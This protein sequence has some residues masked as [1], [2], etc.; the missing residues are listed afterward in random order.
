MEYI[1]GFI[2]WLSTGF[3]GITDFVSGIPEFIL[4]IFAYAYFWCIKLWIST[5]IFT[6][7]LAYEVAQLIL[8]D[9]E[10]YTLLNA[11]FNSMS[12]D[13]RGIAYALGIVEAI[14][15]FID[16]CATAMV[17]RIMGW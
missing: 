2:D 17:L 16:A 5:Q 13:V 6:I 8:E 7:E 10:V 15:I 9:Y 11:A 3:V 14:R 1:H 4:D 12:D